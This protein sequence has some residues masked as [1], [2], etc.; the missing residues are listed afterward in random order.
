MSDGADEFLTVKEVAELLKLNPQTVRNMGDRGELPIVR[1]GSRRVR[2]RRS[3]LDQFL[4]AGAS[5]VA[6]NEPAPEVDEGSITAWA[7][8]GAAIAEMTGTLELADRHQIVRALDALSE[9]THLDVQPT[10]R[11]LFPSDKLPK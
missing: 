8:F 5:P 1:V 2:I 10:F 9:A 6:T 7:T 3:D 4:E 11:S